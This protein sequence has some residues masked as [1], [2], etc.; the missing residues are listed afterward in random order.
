MWRIYNLEHIVEV[1]ALSA[2]GNGYENK[3]DF[4]ES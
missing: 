4:G 3:E 1:R 2:E